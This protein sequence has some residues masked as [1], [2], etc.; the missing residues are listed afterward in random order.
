MNSI[1]KLVVILLLLLAPTQGHAQ[2]PVVAAA[3][4][5]AAALARAAGAENILIIAPE[6][7]QHPPDY[8]PKPSD[9][10][11]MR[12]ADFIILGG[13]EGFAQRMRNAAGS[14]AQLVEVHLENSPKVIRTEVLRLAHL[15]GTTQKAEEY[16][17]N[18][19][20]EY[21]NLSKTLH[22]HFAKKGNRAAAQV[23]MT[24]WAEFAGLELVG[25]FG[26]GPLQPGDLLRLSALKPNIILDNAHMPA[27]VPLAEAAGAGRVQLINFPRPGMDLLDV[28][29]EN[30]R[31]LM[32]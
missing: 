15:F 3:T 30:A 11:R 31:A 25:T 10:L 21:A 23:F 17:L 27:G 26:P 28:F 18:F 24:V 6:T 20:R 16:L 4:G 5:W 12:D 7:L 29:R 13:F 1:I 9:L 14:H 19:D 2:S 8:D 32:P 22:E